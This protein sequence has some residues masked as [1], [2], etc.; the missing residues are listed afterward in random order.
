[1]VADEGCRGGVAVSTATEVRNDMGIAARRWLFLRSYVRI[2]ES[3]GMSV[4]AVAC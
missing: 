3:A 2:S 1:M 4:L